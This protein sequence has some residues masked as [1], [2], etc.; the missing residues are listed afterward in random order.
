MSTA[1]NISAMNFEQRT[2]FMNMLMNDSAIF[3]IVNNVCYLDPETLSEASKL[4]INK[5]LKN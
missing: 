5:L 2:K 1:T 3:K 4:E